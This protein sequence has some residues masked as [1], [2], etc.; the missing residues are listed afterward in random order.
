MNNRKGVLWALRLLFGFF[1]IVVYLGMAY[2]MTINFFDW[3]NTPMWNALRWGM[4]LVF[5]LYGCYRCYRQIVGIDYY[6]TREELNDI[7]DKDK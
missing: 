7:D 5:G 6:R 2:L 1:M 3:D 4:A